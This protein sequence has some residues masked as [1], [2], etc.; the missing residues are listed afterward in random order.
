AKT[1][2]KGGCPPL[3]RAVLPDRVRDATPGLWRAGRVLQHRRRL[4]GPLVNTYLVTGTSTGIGRACAVHLAGLGHHVYAGVRRVEDVDELRAVSPERITPVIL[5]VT[6]AGHVESVAKRLTEEVEGL[7][8]LVNNAGIGR[9]GPL[10]FLDLDE[11]REQL[12]VN[13]IGQVAVTK[14]LLPLIRRSG[15]RV[16]FVGSIL[17]KVAMPMLGP[18]N[19]S[20]FALEGMAEALRHDLSPWGIRVCIVEPGTIRT[21]MLEKARETADRLE[22]VLP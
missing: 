8:G 6:D 2:C 7:D 9:G 20:K 22:R 14:A 16:V 5:D 17:G 1:G 11:W 21:P 13:F 4:R 15:G 12:E 19:A 3:P 10:E 18:Y